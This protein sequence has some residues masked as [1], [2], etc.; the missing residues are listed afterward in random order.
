MLNPSTATQSQDDPTIRACT[1]HAHFHRFG[2]ISVVNLFPLRTPHPKHLLTILDQPGPP[3]SRAQLAANTRAISSAVQSSHT[4]LCAW[5]N[6][7]LANATT[8]AHRAQVCALLREHNRP[9]RALSITKRRQPR[10]PL[11]APLAPL[12]PFDPAG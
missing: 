9:C 11:Y 5:G 6:H 7:A 8:R 12:I 1:R 10:H 3:L 2:S 4:V